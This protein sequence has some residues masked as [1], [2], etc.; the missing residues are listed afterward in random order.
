MPLPR[1]T[2][3]CPICGDKLIGKINKRF[4][5]PACKAR[6][7][8]NRA[9]QRIPVT[10]NVDA[11]LHRNWKILSELHETAGTHKL[12]VNKAQLSRR[13]F[14]FDYYTTSKVNKEQKPYYYVYDFAWMSFSEKEMMVVKL[15]KPK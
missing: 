13:G 6:Y 3:F 10:R 14:H 2:N 5:S 7:H 11:I 15:R 12:F 9:E 8:R 1:P 4:C